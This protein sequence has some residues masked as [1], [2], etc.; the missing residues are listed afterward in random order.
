MN[1]LIIFLV[2]S[3]LSISTVSAAGDPEAG[4]EKAMVCAACHG[5][6]G[7][8]TN[9]VWPKLAGQHASYTLKQLADFKAG[10]RENPQ[11]SPMAANLSEQD[12]ADIAAYF[13]SQSIKIGTT[14]PG[15]LELGEKIYRAGNLEAGVPACIACHGP[16]GQGNPLAVYPKLSGQHAAY[17]ET[18]L[19]AFRQDKRTNDTNEVMRTIV[20]RMT[21]EE[22]MAVSEYVQGLHAP[23]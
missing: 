8:S 4:R 17:T 13:A 3:L 9:P 6:D 19:N 15:K 5:S 23:R 7:N 14:D 22:I 11:M 18:Q 10:R 21:D 2:L 16:T 20:D 1:R 12:M